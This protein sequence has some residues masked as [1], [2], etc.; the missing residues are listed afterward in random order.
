[1]RSNEIIKNILKN[2]KMTQLKLAENMGYK[3]GNS[4][5]MMLNRENAISIETLLKA[6]NAMNCQVAIKDADGNEYVITE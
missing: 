2:Q 5:R 1:M 4:V 6:V 3:G